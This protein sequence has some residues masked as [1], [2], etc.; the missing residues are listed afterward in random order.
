M[1]RSAVPHILVAAL[2]LGT[3]VM[4][5]SSCAFADADPVEVIVVDGS[6]LGPVETVL[7]YGSALA[8]FREIEDSRG[9]AIILEVY[10]GGLGQGLHDAILEAMG[11]VPF[12]PP[13]DV[14]GAV[15]GEVRYAG[16]PGHAPDGR[17]VESMLSY[18]E[19][20]GLYGLAAELSEAASLRPVAPEVQASMFLTEMFCFDPAHQDRRDD[21]EDHDDPIRIEE[22]QDEPEPEAFWIREPFLP[23]PADDPVPCFPFTGPVL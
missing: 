15:R 8:E 9:H 22:E 3:V 11:P 5:A 4:V 18:F 20:S 17:F 10:D 14:E 16:G 1:R 19:S 7:M 21:D 6:D 2:F 13:E 23:V 12:L